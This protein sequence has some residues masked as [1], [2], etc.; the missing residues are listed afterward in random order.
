M[1]KPQLTNKKGTMKKYKLIDTSQQIIYYECT[2]EAN[3]EKEAIAKADN[4][5]QYGSECIDNEI[6]AIEINQPTKGKYDK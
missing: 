2:V 3:S 6:E 4:W 1:K 5:E